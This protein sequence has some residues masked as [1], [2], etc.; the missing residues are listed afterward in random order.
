MLTFFRRVSKSKVGTVIM[1][2]VLIAILAG[3]AI[4]DISNFGSGKL[5]FGMGSSTLAK[6]GGQPVGDR[7]MSDAMQRRLQQAREQNAQADYRSIMGDFEKILGA[8]TDSRALIA[9][10][11]KTGFHL[12][13]RLVDAGIA[14]IPQTR[15]L[16]GQFSE[17]AYQGFLQQQR[18]SDAQV[19]QIITSGLLERMITGPVGANPRV[20][21]GQAS[22]YAS[23]LLEAREGEA[24]TIPVELFKAGLKPTD[25]DLQRYYSANRP[26]YMVPE[27][28]VIR[29]ASVGPEQVAGIAASD[30]DV[31]AYYNANKATY[32]AKE[33]RTLSQAVVP[34]QATANAIAARAKSGATLAAAAAPAGANAAVTTVANQNRA[35]YGSAAGDRVAA[36]AFAA[37]AG[38]VVGPLQSDFGWVVV[39][40]DSVKT[41]GGKTL[42]QA[43]SEIAAKLT[44]EKRKAAIEDIVDK[45]QTAIDDGAN[46]AEAVGQ[47]KLPVTTTPLVQANGTSRSDAG[48]K[49]REELKPA[50]APGFEMAA[51]DPPEIVSLGADKGYA[52]VSPAEVVAA[53][54]APLASIRDRVAADWINGQALQRAQA[55][56]D[57]IGKK[58]AGGMSLAEAVKASGTAL[59]PVRPIA[60]RRIQIAM[61]QGEV[62]PPMKLLFSLAQ[63]KSRMVPAGQGRGFFVVKVNKVVPGN[64]LLQPSLIAR[65][66]NE[67]QPAISQ[68]YTT[69]FMAA[70]RAEMKVERNEGAIQAMKQR[71]ASGG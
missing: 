11:D 34:D 58:A 25:A 29:I 21:V 7:E 31:V 36:A 53:A 6:V 47:S 67:L 64:A 12:S 9:F 17:Q 49:L 24:A 44:A 40:V 57:A 70:V 32:G 48:Y 65:M 61:S 35:A 26:R 52:V 51:N 60:A 18:M 56:A 59:P 62:P 43:R 41:E 16:N 63:G 66:Q 71:L 39:K 68:D 54:P 45:V 50:L 3:F 14:E 22:P 69:E 46:F 30:Q 19:R 5:G 4:A 13:K 15:G 42:D 1:A 28:R 10:A 38:G 55:A 8:L 20:S 23:M 37:P 2:A 33:V 27:Q